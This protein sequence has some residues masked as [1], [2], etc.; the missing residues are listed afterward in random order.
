M[1]DVVINSNRFRFLLQRL[2]GASFLH[3]R[4][5]EADNAS[6]VPPA[7]GISGDTVGAVGDHRAETA[8]ACGVRDKAHR[9]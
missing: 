7:L 3:K 2:T 4:G 9:V 1:F 5:R 8:E 6:I